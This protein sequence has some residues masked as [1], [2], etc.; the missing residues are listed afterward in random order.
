[1][2]RCCLPNCP[3]QEDLQKNPV[4]LPVTE[5]RFGISF[6]AATESGEDVAA[7]N[8]FLSV[9]KLGQAGQSQHE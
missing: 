9:L 6:F 8:H 1:M 2:V 4:A 5:G 7:S 3:A